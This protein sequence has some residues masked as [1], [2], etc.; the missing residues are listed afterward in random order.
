MLANFDRKCNTS[1]H[2]F[3]GLRKVSVFGEAKSKKGIY[4]FH[5]VKIVFG[6]RERCKLIKWGLGQIPRN[7]LVFELR[8]KSQAEKTIQ[9]GQQAEVESTK[10]QKHKMHLLFS[11]QQLQ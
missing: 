9:F 4:N 5:K 8:A 1:L 11:H 3:Q 7:F 6:H 10:S 2:L